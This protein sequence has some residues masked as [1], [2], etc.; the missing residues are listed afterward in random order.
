MLMIKRASCVASCQQPGA[1][2]DVLFLALLSLASVL[3]ITQPELFQVS[4]ESCY[5]HCA[6]M[7]PISELLF[8]VHEELC[9]R[10]QCLDITDIIGTAAA[11]ESPTQTLLGGPP[12]TATGPR[13]GWRTAR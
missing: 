12:P 6:N 7:P 10:P 13:A 3:F 5:L 9:S 2:R 8:Q 4:L 1:M 11:T